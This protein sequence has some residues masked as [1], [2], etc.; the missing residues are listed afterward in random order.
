MKK[1][2]TLLAM[3]TMFAASTVFAQ[4]NENR[5]TETITT[6]TTVRDND[7][8][9]VS[10]EDVT[11][12]KS[13]SIQLNKAEANQVNQEVSVQPTTIS[14]EVSYSI[15]DKSYRFV[16]EGNSGNYRLVLTNDSESIDN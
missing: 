6:E 4:V 8:V 11:V 2:T 16:N 1:T 14:T 7:G 5:E 12:T 10:R 13:Q 9:S 3:F 15:D